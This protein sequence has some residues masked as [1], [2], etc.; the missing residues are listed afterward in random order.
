MGEICTSPYRGVL[1]EFPSEGSSSQE[2]LS[3]KAIFICRAKDR[4]K[5]RGY[6]SLGGVGGRDH[7][8]PWVRVD[9]HKRRYS[10]LWDGVGG[11]VRLLEPVGRS[12]WARLLD[13]VGTKSVGEVTQALE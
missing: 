10:S 12:R 3:S 8:S 6:S 9:T 1:L 13:L 11:E 2:V 7:S 5:G 4:V